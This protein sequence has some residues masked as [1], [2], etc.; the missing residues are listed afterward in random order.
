MGEKN[1]SELETKYKFP[2]RIE[3]DTIKKLE[4]LSKLR[5]NSLK[6]THIVKF[7]FPNQEKVDMKTIEN[8]FLNKDI[9]FL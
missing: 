3:I 4:N 2:D 1:F 7:I 5:E 8:I 6:D 9:L